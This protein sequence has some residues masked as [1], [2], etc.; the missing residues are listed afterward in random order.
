MNILEHTDHSVKKQNIEYF[1]Q[2][3]RIA[4]AD[5]I[6]TESEMELLHRMG[7]KL[8]F[9]EPEINNIIGTTGKSNFIA[10]YELSARFEQVYDI[11]RMTLADGI[12]DKNEMRLASSFAANSGFK[13]SEISNLLVLLING[14]KQGNDHEDLFE[15]YKKQRKF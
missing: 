11:V 6:I 1:V 10:P 2:L 3:I 13:E 8:C 5:D 15:V 4:L 9:T 7:K 12:I 14:I